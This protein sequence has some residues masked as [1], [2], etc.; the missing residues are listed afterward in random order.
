MAGMIL[1][2]RLA[3]VNIQAHY[4]INSPKVKNIEIVS[5]GSG[6]HKARLYFLW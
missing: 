2:I 1:A 5:R 3:G 4:L 6:D